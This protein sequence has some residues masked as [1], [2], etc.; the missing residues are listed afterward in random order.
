MLVWMSYE[1][2]FSDEDKAYL[3]RAS[4]GQK[5]VEFNMSKVLGKYKN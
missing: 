4:M 5:E 2:K 3:L 1:I